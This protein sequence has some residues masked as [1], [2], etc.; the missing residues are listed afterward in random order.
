VLF[1][2]ADFNE[3][4]GRDLRETVCVVFDVLRATSSII[5]ALSNGAVGLRPVAE[6]AEAL[7]ARRQDPRALLAGERDGL[8]I[9]AD[10]AEGVAFDLGNSPR[11]FTATRV[12]GRTIVTTTTNGT[13]ALRACQGARLILA[14]ALLNLT[15][16]ARW[17]EQARPDHL[18][19]VAS[20][21]FE[22]TA[23]ED[24]LAAGALCDL[25]WDRYRDGAVSD[26]ALIARKL[27]RL[28]QDDLLGALRQAR[29]GRRLMSRSEL[30]EDVAFCARRDVTGVVARL[31]PDGMI[32]AC[33]G[34]MR[35]VV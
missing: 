34:E 27:Y 20:G 29:N 26:A 9:Q 10:Q 4:S 6:I 3:L 22:Q 35:T 17:V 19:L 32:R 25:L 14:G 5:T 21:T 33:A 30:Q 13:R 18:L 1:T 2:P 28:E 8:L 31:D 11:E 16:T 15:A 24:V 23:Y 7:D 12:H